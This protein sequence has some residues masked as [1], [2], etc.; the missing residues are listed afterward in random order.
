MNNVSQLFVSP[1]ASIREAIA[2]I[3]RGGAQIALVVGPQAVLQGTVTDGDVRRAI[4]AG[5]ALDEAVH[6]IMNTHFSSVAQGQS[7]EQ[8]F[9]LMREK[10]LHQ[11]PVLDA[12]KQVVGLHLL[13]E[14]M[15][16]NLFPNWVVL[17]AGGMGQRL[18]PLTEKCP[19]PMLHVGPR[20]LLESILISFIEQGFRRFFISLNYRGEQ[21]K[22]H[23]GD[24]ERWG[25]QIEYLQESERMGTAGA[26]AMLPQEPADPVL[27]MN[28]DVLTRVDFAK[29]L[30][31]HNEHGSQ[32]TMCVREY[33]FEVPYGVVLLDGHRIKSIE[34]K[35][36]HRFF[37]N[38]GIYALSAQAISKIPRGR[39]FDMPELFQNIV[40][41][42]IE[43][44]V[45]PVHEYWLDVG[46][47]DDFHRANG[48]YQEIFG[49]AGDD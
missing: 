35:P 32:A 39:S 28:A 41:E 31:F 10:Q 47:L 36:V 38:A 43:T 20:P 5:H 16:A 3:D 9:T 4:I 11:M 18:R 6:G 15:N 45:F 30:E 42:G 46:R 40:D 19:K 25:V 34:E 22:K 44:A 1:E 48:E 49:G 24:G 12:Q 7:R 8:V 33:D 2:I 27:V 21:I 26:L 23:F 17:M 14:L 29:L 37:V 13:D